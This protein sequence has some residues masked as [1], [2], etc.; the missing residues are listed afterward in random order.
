M[1]NLSLFAYLSTCCLCVLA[2]ERYHFWASLE[3]DVP[4]SLFVFFLI[5]G[6]RTEAVSYQKILVILFLQVSRVGIVGSD[7]AL[8]CARLTLMSTVVWLLCVIMDFCP[9]KDTYMS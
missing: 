2:K 1:Y 7:P 8:A 3:G 5:E 6:A 9:F 4:V